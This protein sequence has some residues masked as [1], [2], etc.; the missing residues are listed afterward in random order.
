MCLRL[1]QELSCRPLGLGGSASRASAFLTLL[2]AGPLLLPRGSLYGPFYFF[3]RSSHEIRISHSRNES[4]G[5]PLLLLGLPLYLL[6]T[7]QLR[8]FLREL[9]V[10]DRDVY[11]RDPQTGQVLDPVYNVVAHGLG[12]LWDRCAVLHGYREVDGRLFLS[13]LHRYAA[14]EVQTATGRVAAGDGAGH[15]AQEPADGGGGA[16]AHLD[17]LDLLR[18]D[19]GDFRDHGVAYAG[20]TAA[21][22]A[23]IAPPLIHA[24]FS[25]RSGQYVTDAPGCARPNIRVPTCM[26]VK[27]DRDPAGL[28]FFIARTSGRPCG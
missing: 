7:P 3:A 17:L 14:G 23:A 11:L 24:S 8:P 4:L 2:A 5:P 20:G 15:A 25:F 16:A 27:K 13:Y 28:R 19:P 12:G 22:G 6:L 9:D 26:A 21:V 1:L 18:G 10:V